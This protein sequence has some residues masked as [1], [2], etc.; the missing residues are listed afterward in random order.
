VSNLGAKLTAVAS[1]VGSTPS[2]PGTSSGTSS[3]TGSSNTGTSSTGTSS[4]TATKSTSTGTTAAARRYDW[5]L[6][7][8]VTR[9]GNALTVTLY[10]FAEPGL[11]CTDTMKATETGFHALTR[12]VTMNAGK[13]DR[14]TLKLKQITQH[15]A[16]QAK[17]AKRATKAKAAK[18]ASIKLSVVS[19]AYKVSKTLK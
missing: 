15:P 13:T 12:K 17:Q 11:K 1:A 8:K 5:G 18:R 14:F 9:T 4:T 16:K 7:R 19:G 3:S 2:T 10:C 6:A